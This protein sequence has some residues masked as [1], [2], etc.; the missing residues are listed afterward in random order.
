MSDVQKGDFV[1]NQHLNTKKINNGKEVLRNINLQTVLLALF[2]GMPDK[3]NNKSASS[4]KICTL[5]ISS[6]VQIILPLLIEMS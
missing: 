6:S 3:L 2:S 5:G 1:I 4:R